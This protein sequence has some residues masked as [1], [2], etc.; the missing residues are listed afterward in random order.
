LK[1]LLNKLR[2]FL[3]LNINSTLKEKVSG[4][5]ESVKKILFSIPLKWETPDKFHMTVRF[6]GDVAE[7]D[8]ER[9]VRDLDNSIFNFDKLL[10]L[11]DS[12]DCFPNKKHPNVLILKLTE[13][14][15]NSEQMTGEID[16]IILKYGIKP[17]KK[18]VPHLTLGRFRRENRQGVEDISFPEVEAINFEFKSF[19]LMK[20]V[21]DFKGAQ[22]F[23]IKEFPFRK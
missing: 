13:N 10:F 22:H 6:L 14:E 15:N 11:S 12:I 5:Q 20:S 2:T 4:I 21:L 18:F 9:M 1:K 16:R 23:V 19:Y 8:V 3:S 7:E 17:D